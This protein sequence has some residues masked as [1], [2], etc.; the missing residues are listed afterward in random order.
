[1]GFHVIYSARKMGSNVAFLPWSVRDWGEEGPIALRLAVFGPISL[2]AGAAR[3]RGTKEKKKTY[4]WDLEGIELFFDDD[5]DV[6][7]VGLFF[8]SLFFFLGAMVS[9]LLWFSFL[10][11]R[12]GRRGL[13]KKHRAGRFEDLILSIYTWWSFVCHFWKWDG[14]GGELVSCFYSLLRGW[15]RGNRLWKGANQEEDKRK[16]IR[17]VEKF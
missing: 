9:S 17:G 10:P 11:S 6:D 7:V 13:Y 14:Q 8:F 15:G 16:T 4:S 3:E 12:R 5:D 1:M 2:C